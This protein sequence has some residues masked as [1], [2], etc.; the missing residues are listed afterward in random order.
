MKVTSGSKWSPM[1]DK[2]RKRQGFQR[3]K[4]TVVSLALQSRIFW[5]DHASFYDHVLLAVF[6]K[7]ATGSC[8]CRIRVRH[9]DIHFQMP[10]NITIHTSQVLPL[11]GSLLPSDSRPTDHCDTVTFS[12]ILRML[13]LFKK[14]SQHQRWFAALP[15]SGCRETLVCCFSTRGNV[16]YMTLQRLGVWV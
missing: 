8:C 6:Q 5:L 16:Q 3:F 9:P 12:F 4:D 14:K 15:Q 11:P 1:R 7:F 10:H 13:L 2:R